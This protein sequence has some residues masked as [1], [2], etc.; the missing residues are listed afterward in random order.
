MVGSTWPENLSSPRPSARPL[1]DEPSQPRKN[2]SNCHSASRPKQPG[3]TGS[4]L[5]WQGKNQ[6]SGLTSSVARTKPLPYS[7]PA[8]ASSEMRSNISIGGNGNCGP[9]ENISPRP[10]ASR[11]SNSK[12]L[13]RFSIAI[14]IEEVVQPVELPNK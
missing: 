5:K 11:S 7:P 10:Q 12:Q 1:P 6:R 13:R 8:S 9:S 14:P 2:P 4:P 3:I